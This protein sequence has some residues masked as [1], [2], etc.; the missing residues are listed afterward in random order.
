MERGDIYLVSLDPTSG[1]EQ[2]GMRPV[3]IVSPGKFNRVMKTPVIV[4][5]TNGGNF[6]RSAGFTISL[7]G[8]GTQTTG[9]VLCS[10]PRALD[11]LSRGGRKIE[12]LP[13]EL[14]DEVRAKLLAILD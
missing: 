12:R 14:M 4:P 11:V 9:V 1:H 10:Q 2:Q 5:I 13:A 3:L 6:A 7:S 8:A